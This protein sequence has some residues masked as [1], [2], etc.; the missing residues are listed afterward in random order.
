MWFALFLSN[1]RN[2]QP[3]PVPQDPSCLLVARTTTTWKEFVTI[4][5]GYVH[6]HKSLIKRDHQ[7]LM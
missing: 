6:L 2:L 1:L 3:L 4:P 5:D 7:I